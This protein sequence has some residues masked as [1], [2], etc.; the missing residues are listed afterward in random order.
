MFILQVGE[1]CEGV[2]VLDLYIERL[3]SDNQVCFCGDILKRIGV[4]ASRSKVR[5]SL[6]RGVVPTSFTRLSPRLG[7]C[8]EGVWGDHKTESEYI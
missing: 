2:S 4:W 3:K 5:N 1:I 7:D 6:K 8:E